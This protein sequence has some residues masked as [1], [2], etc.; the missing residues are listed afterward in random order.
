MEGALHLSQGSLKV[1]E[2]MSGGVLCS[3]FYIFSNAYLFF[4]LYIS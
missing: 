4:R 2:M 3:P 1:S